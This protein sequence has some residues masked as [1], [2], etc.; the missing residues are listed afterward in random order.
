VVTNINV[1][2]LGRISR[3][4]IKTSTTW[5]K[6]W[7]IWLRDLIRKSLRWKTA[8]YYYKSCS[9]G[10]RNYKVILSRQLKTLTVCKR[11]L[12]KTWRTSTGNRLKI[13]S[14]KTTSWDNTS[15][16]LKLTKRHT[17]IRTRVGLVKTNRILKWS[18][19]S[20]TLPTTNLFSSNL[21]R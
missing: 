15:K 1:G 7:V 9:H 6:K 2:S 4:K 11:R 21:S 8:R 19:S 20:E 3:W 5:T 12:N 17:T 13:Y 16:E 18:R 14:L 10:I